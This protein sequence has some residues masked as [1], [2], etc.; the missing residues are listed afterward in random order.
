MRRNIEDRARHCS[1]SSNIAESLQL[2]QKNSVYDLFITHL[3]IKEIK[4]AKIR[5]RNGQ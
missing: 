3:D 2:C 4:A 1:L 5:C